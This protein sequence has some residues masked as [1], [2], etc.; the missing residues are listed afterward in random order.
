MSLAAVPLTF[1]QILHLC[2]MGIKTVT[3]V[4]DGGGTGKISYYPLWTTSKPTLKTYTLEAGDD[5]DFRRAEYCFAETITIEGNEG[6]AWT[7]SGDL[8]GRQVTAGV[9]KTAS[10][11]AF[12]MATK[13]ITDSG[14]G[15]AAF[16]TGMVIRVS[17][18]VSNDGVYTI[19]TG[20]VA[21]EIVVTESLVNESSGTPFTI[22]QT[23]TGGPTG[24]TIPT[25]EEALFGKCKLYIDPT[26]IGTTLVSNT[27]LSSSI[28]ISTGIRGQ[29]TASGDLYFSHLEYTPAEVTAELKFLLNPLAKSELVAWKAG[30]AR[31]L[32]LRTL[33]T[34]L[35]TAG[36]TYTYKTFDIDLAGKWEK[37]VMSDSNGAD[38][39]TGTFRS[40]YNSTAAL[41]AGI[42]SVHQLASV[43]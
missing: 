25:V 4:A 22:D 38:I 37:F 13:K 36:T 32:R 14:N 29:Q 7:M 41:F 40:R 35:G 42:R 21:A 30:T 19:A 23:F 15:L 12:V 9:T 24:L 18:T 8:I 33:G 3:P 34:A 26:T 28:K 11:I 10:T 17:G 27:L 6:E 39:F 5:A 1:E 2:E 20:G 31:L 43:P 16:T